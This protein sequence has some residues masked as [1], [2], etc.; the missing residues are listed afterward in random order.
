MMLIYEIGTGGFDV[1]VT[2]TSVR[3]LATDDL[4]Q[5]FGF[6]GATGRLMPPA[7]VIVLLLAMHLARKDD[8]RPGGATLL[9]MAGESAAL[10]LPLVVLGLVMANV[11]L[12]ENVMLS[13]VVHGD[14]PDHTRALVLLS[15]GAGVYEELV[16][17]LIA[18]P[19]LIMLLGDVL[20]LKP[21]AAL[22]LAVTVSG[23]AFS[24]HHYRGDEAFAW[25]SFAFRALAGGY[26]GVL[27]HLR[28]FGVAA[29]THA[30]YD[31][32]VVL[33]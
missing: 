25:S 5:A 3:V 30:A 8:W 6:F 32:I 12:V 17:R 27:L 23:L 15:F 11:M 24:L 31:L 1:P 18:V 29:G 10:A 33:A 2:T 7:A 13:G 4:A 9:G 22:V 20:G 26:F 28:G 16:F 14:D 21:L 19:V